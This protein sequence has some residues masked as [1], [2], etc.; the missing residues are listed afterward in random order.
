MS[1]ICRHVNPVKIVKHLYEQEFWT[2]T[3]I[4]RTC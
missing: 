3:F 2:F 1:P 4:K